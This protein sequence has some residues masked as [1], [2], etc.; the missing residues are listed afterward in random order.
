MDTEVYSNTGGQS[1]KATPRGAVAKF[2]AK[3]KTTRK[4]DLG[5][6][7]MS[8]SNVYVASI[9]M[10]AGD[11]QTMKAITEAE[12]YDGPSIVIA[13]A[14]CIAHGIDMKKGL[15]QQDLAV[16]S[17]MWPLYRFDPRRAEA[18]KS[19]LVLDSKA[20]SIPLEDYM[21]GESRFRHLLKE[22]SNGA[23][24]H[25]DELRKG[26]QNQKKQLDMIAHQ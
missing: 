19:P 24:E 21:Q 17:G 13:Y 8:Y 7:A 22:D 5:L 2:A 18:G 1:S 10:G 26:I 9:A 12:E 15:T 16:K 25:L 4:K 3:G 20:A 14:H 11:A 6:M 23:A